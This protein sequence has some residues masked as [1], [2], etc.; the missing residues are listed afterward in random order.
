MPAEDVKIQWNFTSP[1]MSGSPFK[2]GRPFM[3]FNL[4][5]YLDFVTY[6]VS[7]KTYDVFWVPKIRVYI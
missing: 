1:T 6:F 2:G 4:P 5:S 7:Q 3:V